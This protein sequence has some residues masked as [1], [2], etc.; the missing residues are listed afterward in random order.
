MY[1]PNKQQTVIAQD[2]VGLA[3]EATLDAI[4]TAVEVLDNFISSSRGLVTEDSAAAI[5][6]NLDSPTDF[7]GGPV[8]VGTD[9]VEITFTGTTKAI[10]VLADHDNAGTIYGGG[11]DVEDDGSNAVTRMDSGEGM[12]WDYNDGLNPLYV[13]A[14][15]AAQK[16]F[17]LALLAP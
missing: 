10:H 7:E 17:K 5:K 1:R 8:T 2:D 11:S 16:V 4:K 14:S 3:L 15:E 13:V 6:S 12:G 9:A